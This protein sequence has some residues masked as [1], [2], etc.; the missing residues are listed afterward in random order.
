MRPMCRLRALAWVVPFVVGCAHHHSAS[1]IS[2]TLP[3]PPEDS[4]RHSSRVWLDFSQHTPDR[5]C[6]PGE[7]LPRE[8]LP[9]CYR[10]V[11]AALERALTQTLW[12]SFPDVRVKRKGDSMEPGDYLLLVDL[13]LEPVPPDAQGPGWSTRARV[14]W[15]LVRDGV[16]L[17]TERLEARSRAD[18]PYGSALGIAAGEV[19]DAISVQMARHLGALP[20]LRPAPPMPL[21]A[22]R[23]GE[24]IGPLFAPKPSQ[25]AADR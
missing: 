3:P 11:H 14:K 23:V 8:S 2:A 18:L 17:A 21:P 12:P 10:D 16:S 13:A 6:R 19:V 24:R 9:V 7:S 1:V 20:E 25:L 4:V 15:N 5:Q 22:V